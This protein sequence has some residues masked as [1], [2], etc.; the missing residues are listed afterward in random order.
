[1]CGEFNNVFASLFDQSENH[2]RIVRTFARMRKGMTR[3]Q[4]ARQSVV[5]TGGTLSKTLEEL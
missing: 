1:M 2:E 5:R 4:V 3:D